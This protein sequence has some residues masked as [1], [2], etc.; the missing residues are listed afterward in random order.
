MIGAG[1]WRDRN[2]TSGPLWFYKDGKHPTP[3]VASA[4]SPPSQAPFTTGLKP[5]DAAPKNEPRNAKIK[6]QGGVAQLAR[7]TVS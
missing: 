6:I 4:L 5:P 3:S 7:A 1:H 2:E